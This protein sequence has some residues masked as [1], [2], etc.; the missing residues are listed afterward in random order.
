MD[1]IQQQISKK[2]IRSRDFPVN[3][4][5]KYCSVYSVNNEYKVEKERIN[6]AYIPRTKHNWVNI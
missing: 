3:Y 1:L 4:M 5:C 2:W 6:E